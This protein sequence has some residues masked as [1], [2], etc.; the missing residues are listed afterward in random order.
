MSFKKTARIPIVHVSE[1]VFDSGNLK[2]EKTAAHKIASNYESGARTIDVAAVLAKV[3][4]KYNISDKPEDYIY[5]VVRAVTAEVPNENADAFTKDEL[6]R[7]DHKIAKA[8]YQT[9]IEVPH[10]VNHRADNPKASRGVVLDASYND[11][12]APLAK[13]GSCNNPT[14][15]PEGRDSGGLNCVKCGSVVKDDFIELLLAV[16]T[17]K[18]PTFAK[19]V[20]TGSLSGLSMG[21]FTPETP[22]RLYDGS[23]KPIENIEIGD[24]VLSHTGK[25][26]TVKEISIRDYSDIVYSIKVAGIKDPIVATSEHP[27]YVDGQWKHA[28]CL[29]AG[30]KLLDPKSNRIDSNDIDINIAKL[31]GYMV[32]DGNYI[33]AYSGLNNGKKVGVEFTFNITERAYAEEV[34][35]I[36]SSQGYDVHIY[37]KPESGQCVAKSYK[38]MELVE[39][40]LDLVGECSNE[41]KI[42]TKVFN[43]PEE[44]QLAF[45]GTWINGDG[46]YAKHGRYDTSGRTAITTINKTLVSQLS[47]LLTNLDIP[48]A[49]Q[50]RPGKSGWG[51]DPGI[52]IVIP[53]DYQ[54]KF[55]KYSNKINRES[56]NTKTLTVPS[57]NGLLRPITDISVNLYNGKVY[58]FEIDDDD[59]SYIAGGVAVHNCEARYTICSI[60]GNKAHNTMQF[61]AH[62]RAGNKKKMF[63]TASGNKM[64]YEKCGGVEFTEISRVDQPA[65]PK[66]RTQELINVSASVPSLESESE[67]LMLA[68]KVAKL[69]HMMSKIAQMDPGQSIDMADSVNTGKEEP[70]D[71]QR[72]NVGDLKRQA[73]DILE[74]IKESH[75]KIYTD[76]VALLSD[77]DVSKDKTIGNYAKSREE[78]NAQKVTP[79]EIGVLPDDTTGSPKTLTGSLAAMKICA[80]L[81]AI[82]DIIGQGE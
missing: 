62:I 41:K 12:S 22:I 27:F 73:E 38:C 43:W 54:A 42:S 16:D 2:F 76:I 37:E 63:K 74:P 55:N 24:K 59:H 10:H 75:P 61:C 13:C 57:K 70:K 34:Q 65:D 25:I 77:E 7:F 58:N 19:G 44:K 26:V 80:E 4:A 11:L 82:T 14:L 1:A 67:M 9:F 46:T 78:D 64:S 32:S 35:R 39:Q 8:V 53:G 68:S 51:S 21:C 28:A 5:E 45:I 66:A 15:E 20:R 18:D 36:I 47:Q 81:E 69:E 30:D 6:L 60:C 79:E 71:K 29:I 50:P 3:A 23:S 56:K 31:A 72:G 33:K 49:I 48:H 40:L 52:D 17:K